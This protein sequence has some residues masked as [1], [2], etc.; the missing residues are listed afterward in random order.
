VLFR[1]AIAQGTFAFNN[2]KLTVKD[3]VYY[4]SA[5]AAKDP[6]FGIDTGNRD[7]SGY[8]TLKFDIGGTFKRLGGYAR[9]IAQVYTEEDNDYTPSISLDPIEVK[10][11]LSTVSI[12]LENK[13]PKA[14]KIQFL[15]VT[16]KGSCQ[17]EIRNLRFEL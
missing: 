12:D 4:F 16:D 9:V 13:I 6:G 17:L 14:K 15:L 10:P 5:T 8:R 2:G 3:K 7:I 1:S 11:G